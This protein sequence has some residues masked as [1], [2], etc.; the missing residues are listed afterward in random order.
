MK[1]RYK[2][3]MELDRLIEVG[4]VSERSLERFY[5]RLDELQGINFKRHVESG[6]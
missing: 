3:D 5:I 2:A 1:E 4:Y 6:R